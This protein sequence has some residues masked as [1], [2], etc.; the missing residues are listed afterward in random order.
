MGFRTLA[1]LT[2]VFA[3]LLIAGAPRLVSAADGRRDA[4]DP[5]SPGRGSPAERALAGGAVVLRSPG[6]RMIKVKRS[7][8]WMGSIVPDVL[9]AVA[10]CA[11]EPHGHT[12]K[13]ELF[14]DELSRHKVRLSAYWLDRT[15]VS[16]R[17]YR[18]CVELRRCAAP[19]YV[20]GA[21]RFD[22]PSLP[23]SMVTHKDAIAYCSFRGAR[24]PT[25]AEFERAARGT[26]GRR[27]PWGNVYN[28]RAANHG[29]LG[30]DAT[31]ARDGFAEL[32]PVGS[33]PQG[34]TPDG[35]LDLAGNVA[36]WV[37][38]RFAPGYADTNAIDP[39]GPSSAG[40]TSERV[41]RGGSYVT[42]GPW[43]RGAARQSAEPGTRAPHVGF[44]C[45]RSAQQKRK[46]G[47]DEPG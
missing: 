30:V 11:R 8:F 31:D 14:A 20:E 35:F 18:R 39:Q 44:R 3:A 38:D 23:V 40:A 47:G 7:S 4:F 17:D 6:S 34:R 26:S 9:E 1:G 43:L 36:E 32:A 21:R 24:L 37:S 15:E 46:A 42:A 45:A 25:E 29:R 33:F 28:T 5:W 19:P 27:Y 2:F 12:C 41:V 10:D 13:E 22:K 16:V